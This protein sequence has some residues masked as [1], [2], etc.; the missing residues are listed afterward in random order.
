M[1]KLGSVRRTA[2]A[3]PA[4]QRGPLVTRGARGCADGDLR[5][6]RARLL[7]FPKNVGFLDSRV[8]PLEFTRHVA[9]RHSGHLRKVGG[10]PLAL[11]ERDVAATKDRPFPRH[12]CIGRMLRMIGNVDDL[13]LAVYVRGPVLPKGGAG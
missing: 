3:T 6:E 5:A 4:N 9:E 12:G 1:A 8:L 10:R 7:V 2:L 13:R 11:T